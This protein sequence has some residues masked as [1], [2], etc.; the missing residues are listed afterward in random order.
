MYTGAF[1]DA[2]VVK[3]TVPGGVTASVLSK[4]TGISQPTLSKWKKAR[5]RVDGMSNTKNKRRPQDWSAE[6]KLKAIVETTKLSEEDLG[7]YLRRE[8]LHSSDL[9]QWR[10]DVIEGLKGLR[11]KPKRFVSEDKK[12]IKELEREVRRKD[13]A[14]AEATALLI[15]K[16]KAA[17]IWGEVEE[18]ELT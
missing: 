16:K 5:A 3:M 14:L 10:G 6:E 17:L 9:E 7:L 11:A 18:D 4:E 1:R 8:G 12:K 13:K 2:M 15:L